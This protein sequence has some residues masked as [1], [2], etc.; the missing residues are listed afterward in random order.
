MLRRLFSLDYI[1]VDRELALLVLRIGI[2]LDLFLKHGWEK[3]VYFNVMAPHFFDPLGIGHYTTFMMAFFSD[4]IC[5]VLIMFGVATRWCS[6]YYFGLMFGAWWLRHNFLYW[7]PAP[8][9]P[10]HLAGS[11]GELIT[12][13]L[14]VMIVLFIAGAGRYSVDA[15]VMRSKKSAAAKEELVHA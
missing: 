9:Q 8:G 11:H 14:L 5:S 10:N 4:V 12:V 3:I 7:N 1:K 6:V 15:L 2:G 13:Y